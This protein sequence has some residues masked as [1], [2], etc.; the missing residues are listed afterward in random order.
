MIVST[1]SSGGGLPKFGVFPNDQI[2]TVYL[3][4]RKTTVDPTPSWIFEYAVLQETTEA[5]G[6]KNPPRNQQGLVLPFPVVREKPVLPAELLRKYL[7]RRV[8][9]YSIINI[10]GKMEQMSVK[11][12]PDTQLNELVLNALSKWVFKPGQL[13]GKT[14]PMKLLV[15]IPLSQ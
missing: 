8:I 7:R 11:E 12:S 14:V 2:Y 6:A 10:D 4:M 9:V 15:G 13:G 1:E 3:D 5:N